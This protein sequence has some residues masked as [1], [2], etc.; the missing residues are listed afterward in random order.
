M[1]IFVSSPTRS[2]HPGGRG[3]VSDLRAAFCRAIA[4]IR[5]A[6]PSVCS[7][8]PNNQGNNQGPSYFVGTASGGSTNPGQNQISVSAPPGAV[9]QHFEG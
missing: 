4:I 7:Q 2:Q 9:V 6:D 3:L 1:L 5:G 8:N